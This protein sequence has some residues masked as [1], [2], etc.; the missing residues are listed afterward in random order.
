MPLEYAD[1]DNATRR[2]MLKELQRDIDGGTLY[3]SN[4]LSSEGSNEYPSLLTEALEKGDDGSLAEAL[5]RPGVLRSHETVTRKGRLVEAK[6]PH[7]APQT[8][9]EGE[10]NRYYMRG[11][12]CRAIEAGMDRLVVYRAKQVS[13]PRRESE[14][15]IGAGLRPKD[16]LE[17]LRTHVGIDTALGLPPGPNSGLSIRLS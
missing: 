10:F 9:S 14:E 1:L 2:F 17:D 5:A 13:K 11:L 12:C 15:M 16:L 8:M 7:T 6:V 4:R 3:L